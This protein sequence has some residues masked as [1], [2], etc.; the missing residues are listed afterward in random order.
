MGRLRSKKKKGMK[1]ASKFNNK[2]KR[3]AKSLYNNLIK[4]ILAISKIYLRKKVLAKNMA[5]LKE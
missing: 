5:N 1:K 2:L 4:N 3:E